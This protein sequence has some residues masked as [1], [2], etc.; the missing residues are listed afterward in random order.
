MASRSGSSGDAVCCSMR[1]KLPKLVSNVIRSDLI[2]GASWYEATSYV[3]QHSQK[4]NVRIKNRY[5]WDTG[6]AE[7]AKFSS[8]SY[9]VAS[10]RISSS[11]AGHNIDFHHLMIAAPSDV[12]R[13]CCQRSNTAGIIFKSLHIT[14]KGPLF[15]RGSSCHQL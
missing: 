3:L 1:E 2:L 12:E 10:L 7:S 14:S 13:G 5:G 4:C 15:S 11:L 9:Q 6:K 8:H